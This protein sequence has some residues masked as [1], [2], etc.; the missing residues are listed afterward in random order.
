MGERAWLW[1]DLRIIGRI[2][3]FTP[4]AEIFGNDAQARKEHNLTFRSQ[5]E[6]A[7]LPAKENMDLV[8]PPPPSKKAQ[9]Y[10]ELEKIDLETC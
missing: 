7:V 2:V 10:L 9:Q 8:S 5:A 1:F 4:M 3:N 6:C